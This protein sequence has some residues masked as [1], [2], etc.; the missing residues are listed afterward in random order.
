LKRLVV[1]EF[2]EEQ[3]AVLFEKYLKTGSER[4]VARRHFRQKISG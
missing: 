4:E 2:D 1:V 3:P